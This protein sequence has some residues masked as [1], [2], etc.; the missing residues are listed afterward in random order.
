MREHG[1]DTDQL[2][3]AV[4]STARARLLAEYSLH[5]QVSAQALT[6]VRGKG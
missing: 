2:K 6:V 1:A 5:G 3:K 4:Q